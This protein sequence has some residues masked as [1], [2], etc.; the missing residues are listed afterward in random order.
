MLQRVCM[1]MCCVNNS[2]TVKDFGVDTKFNYGIENE[3]Q[4]CLKAR[5]KSK[6]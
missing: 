1:F 5:E 2:F 3:T 6:H 4:M